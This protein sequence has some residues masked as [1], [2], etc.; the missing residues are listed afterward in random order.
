[1]YFIS[2]NSLQFETE[3]EDTRSRKD[4]TLPGNVAPLGGTQEE[5]SRIQFLFSGREELFAFQRAVSD[6]TFIFN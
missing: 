2:L 1:M 5:I 6:I 3:V 4:V